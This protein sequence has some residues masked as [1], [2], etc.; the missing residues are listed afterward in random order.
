VPCPLQV[1]AVVD[2]CLAVLA[3]SPELLVEQAPALLRLDKQLLAGLARVSGAAPV[4]AA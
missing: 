1:P 2:V 3:A 4:R